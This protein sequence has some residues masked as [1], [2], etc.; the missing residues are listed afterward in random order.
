MRGHR[1]NAEQIRR[2]DPAPSGMPLAWVAEAAGSFFSWSPG[3]SMAFNHN[4]LID[5][6]GDSAGERKVSICPLIV[7]D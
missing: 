2:E 1:R 7:S 4:G 5:S 6:R 3:P